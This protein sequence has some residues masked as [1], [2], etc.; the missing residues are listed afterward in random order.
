MASLAGGFVEQDAGCDGGIEAFDGAGAGDGDGA[1]G[2]GG[3]W[4]GNAI[5]FIPDEERDRAG[6]IDVIGRFGG[7]DRGRE[8]AQ[9]RLAQAGDR[10]DGARGDQ[11]EAE[12]AAGRGTDGLGVPGADGAGRVRMPAAPKASAERRM[13][14]RLPG[15]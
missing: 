3:D 2:H 1:V 14:P 5:A 12:N 10:V 15:S 7:A 4:F 6:E 11:R 9:P 8:D 13:V